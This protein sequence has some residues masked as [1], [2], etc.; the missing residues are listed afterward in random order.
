[1]INR[2]EIMKIFIRKI[3]PGVKLREDDT[4]G[5]AWARPSVGNAFEKFPLA[6]TE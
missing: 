6:V 5:I 4:T 3:K 2:G 1:M